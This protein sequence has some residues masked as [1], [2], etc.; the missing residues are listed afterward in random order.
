MDCKLPWRGGDATA[1]SIISNSTKLSRPAGRGGS[2]SAAKRWDAKAGRAHALTCA[3][4]LEDHSTVVVHER[5]DGEV[6]AAEDQ[7]EIAPAAN[8][9]DSEQAGTQTPLI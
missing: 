7:E 1:P 4:K 5:S 6:G 2:L 8:A 3:S 9:R